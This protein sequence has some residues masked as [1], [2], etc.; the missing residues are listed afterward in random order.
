MFN[1]SLSQCATGTSIFSLYW[2]APRVLL[3]KYEIAKE[4][5]ANLVS[6]FTIS[7]NNVR[8]GLV[9]LVATTVFNLDGSF[10]QTVVLNKIR[11]IP[12][13]NTFTGSYWGCNNV[14]IW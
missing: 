2:I 6:G 3:E 1:M 10:D 12:Y 9:I 13:L 5:V 14:A 11:N 7:E 8:V 4:F